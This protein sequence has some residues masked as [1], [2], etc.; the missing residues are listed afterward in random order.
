MKHRVCQWTKYEA[1]TCMRESAAGHLEKDV[2]MNAWCTMQ[3]TEQN[4]L[5]IL[6]QKGAK[7]QKRV[8]KGSRVWRRPLRTRYRGS[9]TTC[10]VALPLVL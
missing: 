2:G 3:T 5:Q 8:S 4:Y 1:A 7:P 10:F 6:K 9:Q